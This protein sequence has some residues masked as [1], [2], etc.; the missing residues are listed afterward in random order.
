MELPG[1]TAE[2]PVYR[3]A[4]NY[5]MV[6]TALSGNLSRVRV[7]P[8]SHLQRGER[9]TGNAQCASGRCRRR[10]SPFTHCWPFSFG[11]FCDTDLLCT[12]DR[13]CQ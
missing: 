1:F 5:A 7:L 13:F 2:S 3:S 8:A 10:C 9:C 4:E 6:S 11:P 12:I